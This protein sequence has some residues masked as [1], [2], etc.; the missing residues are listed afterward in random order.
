MTDIHVSKNPN[1]L[2]EAKSLSPGDLAI[3]GTEEGLMLT[4]S[5]VAEQTYGYEAEI[6]GVVDG[7]LPPDVNSNSIEIHWDEAVDIKIGDRDWRSGRS[8]GR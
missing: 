8:T 1:P 6:I 2:E 3:V 7:T 4:V 5:I